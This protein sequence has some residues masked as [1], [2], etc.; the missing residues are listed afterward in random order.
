MHPMA[1]RPRVTPNPAAR[2]TVVEFW[3]FEEPDDL[4][5][6]VGVDAA[7]AVA[8]SDVCDALFA[9]TEEVAAEFIGISVWTRKLLGRVK[10][11]EP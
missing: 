8:G 1:A 11:L 7:F 10:L 2:P 6:A 5:L 4:G 3:W 9:A